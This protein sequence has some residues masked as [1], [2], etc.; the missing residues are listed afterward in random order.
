MVSLSRSRWRPLPRSGIDLIVR[1]PGGAPRR[2]HHE[3]GRTRRCPCSGERRP[4]YSKAALAGLWG[5]W[6][7]YTSPRLRS[8]ALATRPLRPYAH[9]DEAV[10]DHM[11]PQPRLR[12]LLADEPGT[13]KTIMTGMYLVGGHGDA[14]SSRAQRHRRSGAPGP[15]MAR[16][17]GGFF[18]IRASRLTPEMARDPKDLDPRVD[19]WVDQRRPVHPQP[20]RAPQGGRHAGVLVARGVRR[21]PPPHAH[22]PVPGGRRGACR[23]LPSPPPA[24]RDAP[25]WQG[26]FLPGL[27]HLLDPELYPWDPDDDRYDA[28]LR[29]GRLSFLRRMKEE[30][31][32]LDG[33]DLFP[34]RYAETVPVDLGELEL[35]AYEAVMDYASAWYGKDSTLALSIYGKRAASSPSGR[36]SLR[37]TGGLMPSPAARPARHG[38]GTRGHCRRTPRGPPALRVRSRIHEDLVEPRTSSSAPRPGTSRPKSTLSSSV[39]DQLD[40][41]IAARRHARQV[42]EAERLMVK[43][44]HQ[45]RPRPAPGLHRVR[46]HGSLARGPVPRR[47]DSPP[48]P[49]REP[50]TTGPATNSSGDSSR[51]SS[52]CSSPRTPA[53][54]A[55]T[56]RAPT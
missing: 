30:L 38:H 11:L 35:A 36:R 28:S 55:S 54:R 6:M 52:R 45:A 21:G 25:P 18:G 56:F 2:P 47:R 10:F 53:V 42:G 43:H 14:V 31:K 40:A 29:P 27:C 9:Q 34:A 7:Q 41:A 1:R 19:V 5:R 22:L 32:D 49:S 17:A 50:S 46:R 16:G 15:E 44:E 4:G 8:A 26:A 51:A 20:R 33:K 13:G 48:R 37:S 3:R 24:H 12:F 23:S 39:L